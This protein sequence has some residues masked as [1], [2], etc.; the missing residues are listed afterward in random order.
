M[1]QSNKSSATPILTRRRP[2]M[3][4]LSVACMITLSVF[5]ARP[6]RIVA[7]ESSPAKLTIKNMPPDAKVSINNTIAQLGEYGVYAV[8]VGFAT[9]QIE[10]KGIAAYTSSMIFKAGDNKTIELHCLEQCATIDIVTD[11]FGASVYLNGGFEG[12][13][14]YVNSFIKPGEYDLDVSMPGHEPVLR[15]ISIHGNKPVVLTLNLEQTQAFR[16]SI[17]VLK[18]TQKKRRQLVQKLLFSGLAA[19]C[20]VGGAY[21]DMNARAHLSDADNAALAYDK[22]MTGFQ[23]YKDT[24]AANR[25]EARK[26]LGNRD[27]LYVAAGAC[28]IGFTFSF[29]F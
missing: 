5:A 20:G 6:S 23:G 3:V 12:L 9:I 10:S 4:S 18:T 15:Q 24:Y 17:R 29:L 26:S 16:D 25:D 28:M 13:T 22:A 8:P 7:A 1:K 21:F 27:L 11:P 2:R 14:P 19:L